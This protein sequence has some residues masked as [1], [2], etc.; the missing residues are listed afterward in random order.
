MRKR[1]T[2]EQTRQL[3]HGW[4][5][6]QAGKKI[7]PRSV[8]RR[9]DITFEVDIYIGLESAQQSFVVA[10]ELI[11]PAPTFNQ[12]KKGNFVHKAPDCGVRWFVGRD[13]PGWMNWKLFSLVKPSVHWPETAQ[14]MA[15]PMV[16]H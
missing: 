7:L 4:K 11:S 15:D 6:R 14:W 16:N 13:T 12:T 1:P 2:E 3:R 8:R 10:E 5:V 9:P